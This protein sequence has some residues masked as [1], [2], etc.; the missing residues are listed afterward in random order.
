MEHPY[1]SSRCIQSEDRMTAFELQSIESSCGHQWALAEVAAPLSD[2][3]QRGGLSR[4]QCARRSSLRLIQYWQW[5]GSNWRGISSSNGDFSLARFVMVCLL[6]TRD[7]LI[8]CDPL[9]YACWALV[10]TIDQ[11]L[12]GHESAAMILRCEGC[13]LPSKKERSGPFTMHPCEV[14]MCSPTLRMF[15]VLRR[16]VFAHGCP[17]RWAWTTLA[18][19]ARPPTTHF[20]SAM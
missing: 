13:N 19:I 3:I 20:S 15:E 14:S 12:T 17:G 8:I 7:P 11:S 5:R 9:V 4:G 6:C 2:C 1:F 18:R 10:I 16:P